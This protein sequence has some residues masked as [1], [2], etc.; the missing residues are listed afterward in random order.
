MEKLADPFVVHDVLFELNGRN[1]ENPGLLRLTH[2]RDRLVILEFV[3]H[4]RV[5]T[6]DH[7]WA[8]DSDHLFSVHWSLALRL[9]WILPILRF[10][11][12]V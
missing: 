1:P 12:Y 8:I 6:K 7:S 2:D 11:Q 4:L 9:S 5:V 3:N 10:R